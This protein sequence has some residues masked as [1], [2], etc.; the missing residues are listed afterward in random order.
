MELSQRLGLGSVLAIAG[1]A[2]IAYLP[3]A[4]VTDLPAPWP[5]LIGFV[6]GLSAG[7]GAALALHALIRIR[8]AGARDERPE[9]ERR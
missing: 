9:G 1:G 3:L 6:C 2:G 4:G 8:G 5:L 7:V